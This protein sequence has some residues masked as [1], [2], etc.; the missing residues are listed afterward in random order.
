MFSWKAASQGYGDN[1]ARSG[2]ARRISLAAFADPAQA[3]F[4]AI[5]VLSRHE[6]EP[7][8]EL[9]ATVERAGLCD[10]RRNG[11]GDDRPDTGDGRQAL[12]HRVA[13]VP[14]HD[15]RLDAGICVSSLTMASAITCSTDAPCPARGRPHHS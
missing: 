1:Q 14:S 6:T 2:R 9:S 4:A 3:R 8:S 13:L 15:L 11:G 7:S 5:G 10:S 12:A